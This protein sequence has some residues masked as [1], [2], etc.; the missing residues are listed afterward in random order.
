MVHEKIG[1]VE[2]SFDLIL[3]LF[4]KGRLVKYEIIEGSIPSDAHIFHIEYSSTKASV[5]IYFY[6][7]EGIDIA[8]GTC[9]NDIPTTNIVLRTVD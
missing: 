5:E 3:Q 7:K 8:P 9:F 6:S 1:K 4:L 2:L